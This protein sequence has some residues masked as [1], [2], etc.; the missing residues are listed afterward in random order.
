MHRMVDCIPSWLPFIG[1]AHV[2]IL[3]E[4]TKVFVS[5]SHV[6]SLDVF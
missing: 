6:L 4:E 5:L 3:L 1:T 2:Q